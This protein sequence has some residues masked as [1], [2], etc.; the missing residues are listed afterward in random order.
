MKK[1][2]NEIRF[3]TNFEIKLPL[4]LSELKFVLFTRETLNNDVIKPCECWLGAGG[5][6]VGTLLSLRY[7]GS[8]RSRMLVTGD[9][10]ADASDKDDLCIFIAQMRL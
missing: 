10:Q 3:K 9:K 6:A 4:I 2:T 8:A 5:A 1:M 7:S